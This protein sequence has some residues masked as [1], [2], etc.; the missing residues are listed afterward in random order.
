MKNFLTIGETIDLVAPSGGV[1]SGTPYLIGALFG[2]AVITAAENEVF[3]L[4]R[5]GVFDELPKEAHATDQAWAAGDLLY[6][7]DTAKKLTKTASGN[8]LVGAAV[9]TVATTATTGSVLII[10]AIA[11]R[12]LA[13]IAA[14]TDNSGGTANDTVEAC[15]AAVSGVD[16]TGSNAASKADV[17]T[18]LTAIA[19]N[20]A[21]LSAKVNA[22]LGAL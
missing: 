9:E 18:R 8:T 22:I 1:V 16:G 2:V 17:D 4:K 14:L 5:Q 12:A 20:F 11:A 10:P 21:D 15:G 3:G 6:W 13:G 19:N 7:D